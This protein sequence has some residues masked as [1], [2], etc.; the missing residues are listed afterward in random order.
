V[1]QDKTA[2]FLGSHNQDFAKMLEVCL[3]CML[4]LC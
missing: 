4:W 2:K 3:F 1:S